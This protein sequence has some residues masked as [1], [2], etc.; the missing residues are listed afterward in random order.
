MPE[1]LDPYGSSVRVGNVVL[2]TPGLTGQ[3]DALLPTAPDTRAEELTSDELERVLAEEHVEPQET[4][5]ITGTSEIPLPNVP[6]RSSAADEP[7]IELEAPDPGPEFG[8]LV[9]YTDESG[10]MTWNFPV[11]GNG[12]TDVTRGQGTRTYLIRRTVPPTPDDSGTRGLIGAVGKKLLK[13]L[14]FPVL[15]P[16]IGEVGQFFAGKWEQKRRRYLVRSFTPDDYTGRDALD[17]GRR[18]HWERLASGPALLLVHGTFSLADTSFGSLPRAT[19]EQFHRWY[20]GRV[21]ALDHFTISHDPRRNVEWFLDQVPDGISLELDLLTSSRGALVARALAEKQSEFSLGS[22]NLDIR[23]IVFGAGPNAGTVLANPEHT[24]QFL[25]AFTNILN[26]FPDN[27][28]ADVISAV[29]TVAKQ[30]AVGVV[31]G[32][33]G[34]QSMRPEGPFLAWLNQ[35]DRGRSRYYALA[36]NFEPASLGLATFKDLVLDTI[37]GV[38]NDLVVPTAGVYEANGAG[39]FPIDDRLVLDPEAGVTHGGFFSN[40]EV[41]KQLQSWL[42]G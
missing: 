39:S 29:V 18:E 25:D 4:I 11:D 6:T 9:L 32:L 28:V 35:G 17:L 19:V 40:H 20:G 37:F 15:D 12:A 5:A 41:L 24:G 8:Q 2:R 21:F 36:S 33:D 34:I 16:V 42:E 38:D 23:R 22:R 26:F 13:V 14:V 7:A 3:A 1:A 31:N 27:G 30:V 10:V